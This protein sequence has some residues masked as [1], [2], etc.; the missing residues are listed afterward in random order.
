M[1]W[2]VAVITIGVGVLMGELIARIPAAHEAA[3]G[4]SAAAI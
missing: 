3:A 4:C 1:K 2:G